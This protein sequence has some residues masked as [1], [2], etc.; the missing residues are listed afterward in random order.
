MFHPGDIRV[1]RA[2]ENETLQHMFLPTSGGIILF[3]TQG[4]QT[5][6]AYMSGGDFDGD[7]YCII[8]NRDIV[9]SILEVPPF[10]PCTPG[11]ADLMLGSRRPVVVSDQFNSVDQPMKDPLG[12]CIFQGEPKFAII[13]SYKSFMS[14]HQI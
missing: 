10:T 4:R 12:Y 11:E 5:P 2:V 6:A 3:S 9:N 1:L 7:S 14:I 13:L 8:Y